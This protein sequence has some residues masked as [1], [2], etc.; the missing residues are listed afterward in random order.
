M[1]TFPLAA[2][3]R[4][5]TEDRQML[6]SI[7]AELHLPPLLSD[8]TDIATGSTQTIPSTEIFKDPVTPLSNVGNS[9][10]GQVCSRCHLKK[11]TF[12]RLSE[13]GRVCSACHSMFL[14]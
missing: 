10:G 12:V 11:L 9:A 8:V 2:S 7:A 3:S 6:N 13:S 5:E 14:L 1:E 4:L